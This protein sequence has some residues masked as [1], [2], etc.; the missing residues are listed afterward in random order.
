MAGK[1]KG[2]FI[3]AV[4]FTGFPNDVKTH[5]TAGVESAPMPAEFIKLMRAKGL[6]D[7]APVTEEESTTNDS[8]ES[9]SDKPQG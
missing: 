7:D 5:F 9:H 4:S 1:Y 2:T 8:E 3:P 6:T